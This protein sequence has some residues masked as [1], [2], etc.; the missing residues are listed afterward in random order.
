MSSEE[1]K[2]VLAYIKH[3][4][5]ATDLAKY[6]TNIAKLKPIIKSGSFDWNNKEHRYWFCEAYYEK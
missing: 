4:I 2:K 5:L 3:C 6:F 1:Y